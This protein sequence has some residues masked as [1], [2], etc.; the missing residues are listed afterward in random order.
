M[1]KSLLKVALILLYQMSSFAHA[2]EIIES[3][4]MTVQPVLCF[5][6]I[7]GFRIDITAAREHRYKQIGRTLCASSQVIYRDSI[8]GP[9]NLD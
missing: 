3:M 9:V 7:A 4:S 1:Y 2:A 8:S 5:H 6:V